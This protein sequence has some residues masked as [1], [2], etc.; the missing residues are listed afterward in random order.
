[1]PNELPELLLADRMTP[2]T[3][4]IALVELPFDQAVEAF[5]EWQRPLWQRHAELTTRIVHGDLEGILHALEPMHTVRNNRTALIPTSANW[6]AFF[7]NLDRGPDLDSTMHSLTHRTGRQSLL[8]AITLREINGV[9]RQTTM[10]DSTKFHL[11]GPIERY[12]Q[13]WINDSDRWTWD[14]AGDIQPFERP[15][16]YQARR[17]KDRLTIE[18]MTEYAAALGL[19]PFDAD[20]YAPDGFGAIVE[21]TGWTC[22]Q[23]KKVSLAQVQARLARGWFT[24]PSYEGL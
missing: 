14:V 11:R 16:L 22:P 6:T 7:E 18:T 17:I 24:P 2:I 20:F 12:L 9:P 8:M 5:L 13:A 19:R 23:C 1:M 10:L 15:E 21:L 4:E 3:N